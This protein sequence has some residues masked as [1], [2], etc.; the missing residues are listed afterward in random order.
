MRW[1]TTD[2]SMFLKVKDFTVY[3]K[4]IWGFQVRSFYIIVQIC[5]AES[6]DIRASGELVCR[7]V[8]HGEVQVVTGSF[9]SSRTYDSLYFVHSER[10]KSIVLC[11]VLVQGFFSLLSV[12]LSVLE[13]I[14]EDRAVFGVAQRGGDRTCGAVIAIH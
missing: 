7:A 6:K 9:P 2:V 1:H 4:V 13:E 14:E 12:G 8:P 3:N 10:S 5:S 11:F